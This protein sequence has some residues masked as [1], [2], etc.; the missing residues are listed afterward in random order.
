MK[1]SRE[2]V[3]EDTAVIRLEGELLGGPESEEI[4]Q[5]VRLALTD[6]RRFVLIDLGKVPWMTSGGIGLLTRLHT[7]LKRS[8]GKLTLLHPSER[9]KRI[10]IVTGLIAVFEC[11]ADEAEALKSFK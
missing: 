8:H 6:G 11:Y 7:T 1:I 4:R 10:L 9:V 5:A 3:G 2:D